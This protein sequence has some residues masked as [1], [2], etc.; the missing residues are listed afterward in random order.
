MCLTHGRKQKK[1]WQGGINFSDD[2]KE[3]RMYAIQDAGESCPVNFDC[4]KI[5]GKDG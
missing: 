2:P 3:K 4:Y 1:N 5:K